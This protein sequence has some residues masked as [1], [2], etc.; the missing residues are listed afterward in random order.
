MGAVLLRN[1]FEGDGPLAPPDND[2]GIPY[3]YCMYLNG[4]T[5]VAFADEQSDLM[6]VLI[7]GYASM[8]EED[9]AF[10]RI[11]LG[12]AAA[13]QVQA[14]VLASTDLQRQEDGSYLAELEDGRQ[15]TVSKQQWGTLVAPRTLTQPRADWWTCPIPLVVVETS[16]EPFT[17]VSRPASGLSDGTAHADNLW[18]IRPA[19]DEDFLLSLHEVGYIRWMENAEYPAL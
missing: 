13:A 12:Q 1:N 15:F 5:D 17:S 7:P 4:F 10:N 19:E 9:Q 2:S 18:W 6:E 11:R 16:Y 14:E 8:S 3:R